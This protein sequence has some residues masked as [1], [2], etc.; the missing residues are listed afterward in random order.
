MTEYMKPSFTVKMSGD[1]SYRDNYDAIDWGC[2][3]EDECSVSWCGA[4]DNVTNEDLGYVPLNQIEGTIQHDVR[5]FHRIMGQP[6]V[7]RPTIPPVERMDLRLKLVAEEFLELLE[8]SGCKVDF[9]KSEI[10]HT[11]S[12][13]KQDD[14][15]LVEIADALCDIAYVVEGMCLECGID[16]E[17]VLAEVQRSNLSKIGEDGKP[18]YNE[19]G[20]VTKGPN[21]SPPD[22]VKSL[23]I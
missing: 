22:I 23:G 8:A 3:S 18:V 12:I 20:K 16:S 2:K 15:D 9:I 4:L 21:Y 19:S 1:Q 13:R 17:A 7:D 5:E 10:E 14:V 6:I 11:L